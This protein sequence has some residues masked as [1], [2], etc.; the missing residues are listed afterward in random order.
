VTWR[1]WQQGEFTSCN[2]RDVTFRRVQLKKARTAFCVQWGDNDY[3]REVYPGTERFSEVRGVALEAIDSD[4]PEPTTFL[5][6]QGNLRS[7][8]IKNSRFRN[9]T[10]LLHFDGPHRGPHRLDVELAGNRFDVPPENLI[11]NKRPDLDI[12]LNQTP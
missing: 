7:L 6:G 5:S 12:S 10:A 4:T 3:N 8:R 1:C 9:I 2:I 11:L